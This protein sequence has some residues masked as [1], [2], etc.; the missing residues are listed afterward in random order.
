[1]R[2][3][4]TFDVG[5][6]K[7]KVFEFLMDPKSLSSCLPD[8]QSLDVKSSDEFAAVVRAGVSFIKGDFTMK[9]KISDRE[10]PNHAKLSARG[11]G[12]ASTIDLEAIM[13]L[14]ED[15]G[16]TT[17]KW[18]AEAKVG[19]RIAAVGQRLIGAQADKMVTQLF[20]CVRSKLEAS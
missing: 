3:E 11:S 10:P 7:S 16:K 20:G 18:T 12:M 2:F 14:S 6:P 17:M 15:A 13:D 1:M 5:V 4:G 8:M 19:G 9:F